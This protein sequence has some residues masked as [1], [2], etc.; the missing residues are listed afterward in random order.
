MGALFKSFPVRQN[1]ETE[2]AK[3][4]AARSQSGKQASGSRESGHNSEDEKRAIKE[5]LI[6]YRLRRTLWLRPR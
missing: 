1:R 2:R 4:G 5:D 3:Q 6:P